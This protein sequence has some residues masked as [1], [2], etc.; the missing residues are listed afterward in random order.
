MSLHHLLWLAPL[1]ALLIDQARRGLLQRKPRLPPA[2][3]RVLI[4]GAS[5]GIGRAI[6]HLYA[7]RGAR[8]C[9]L[10]RREDRLHSVRDECEAIRAKAH[11]TDDTDILAIVADF[12]D[13]ISLVNVRDR[14]VK[15][16]NGLDT[17]IINAGVSA[18]QP[19]L[20]VVGLET[21]Q[22]TVNELP[23]LA[24]LIRVRDVAAAAIRGNFTGPLLSLAAFIPL[25]ENSSSRP[26]TL[27]VSSVAAVIPAPT[28]TLYAASKAAS[29]VLF[30][31]LS[32]EHP[33]VKFTAVLPAT[34]EGDFRASA[35]DGGLVR[36]NL[37]KC[38][39]RE[40][41][42]QACIDAVDAGTRTV[43]LPLLYRIF[44]FL[45]W[46]TPDAVDQGARKKYNFS[47]K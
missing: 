14:I 4:L 23:G 24:G 17:L 33:E 6:A 21:H 46:I 40:H 13:P 27:L 31:S 20:A 39:K 43:W 37:T 45:Y 8:I 1:A 41:V 22:T 47:K 7:A 2:Q 9:I 19:L 38:L 11:T 3:E 34:V 12:S 42:A 30:Q 15:E 26:A 25:L 28:R 29:L 44:H 16:W 35:V 36:E 32:I 5:S 18:L 10:A